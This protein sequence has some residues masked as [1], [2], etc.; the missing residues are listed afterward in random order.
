MKKIFFVPLA[1]IT[2][3]ILLSSAMPRAYASLKLTSPAFTHDGLYPVKFTC[4]G[5]GISPPLNWKGV[6]DGTQSL[7]LIMDHIPQVIPAHKK[8]SHKKDANLLKESETKNKISSIAHQPRLV[9]GVRWY[10]SM[11]NI[12]S[13]I[14]TIKSGS[15]VGIL[16]TN[17]VNNQQKYAPPCSAGP[18]KK[19]YTFHLYAL[20]TFLDTSPSE[21]LSAASIRQKMQGLILDSDTLSISFER[22]CKGLERADPKE[23][24][25]TLAKKEPSII[26]PLCKKLSAVVI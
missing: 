8:D 5:E 19:V 4:E 7:V 11:F 2:T 3:L 26:L 23:N 18:G 10:W 17:V 6:P 14:T 22:H 1:T 24:T 20:S 12:S 13:G 16:G 15:S 25:H 9:E 21:K